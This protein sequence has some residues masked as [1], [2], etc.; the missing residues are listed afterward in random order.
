MPFKSFLKFGL[1]ILTLMAVSHRAFP[2]VITLDMV[3]V[4]NAG[5]PTDSGTGSLYGQVNTVYQ[6]QRT[7]MNLTQYTAFLNAVAK[8]DTFN[9]Y[10]T[11]MASIANIAGISRSGP[12]GNFTY[13]V[14]G[15]GSRPVTYVTWFD[16]ARFANWMANGQPIGA[17]SASTTE[18][19]AYNI[20]GSSSG[21]TIVKNTINPNTGSAVT[22]WIPTE[23]EWYK[24]AYYDPSPGAPSS[25]YWLYPT[26]S[27]TA[28]GNVV[29]PAT[30]QANY[31][32]GKY[33]VTQSATFSGTQNYLTI[34]GAYS[35]SASFYGT[36][37]QGGGVMEWTGT[38]GSNR[39]VRGGSW[40]ADATSLS[41]STRS[42]NDAFFGEYPTLGFRLAAIPEPSTVG[43]L[44]LG[45]TAWALSRRRRGRS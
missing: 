9:L 26:R 19:G 34:G 18:N 11:S 20:N 6:I 30:N 3:L 28:P 8:A 12:S 25:K 38:G 35:N 16:A 45:A 31:N 40:F 10:N 2:A 4:G 24:A 13:S 39:V 32:N 17:Q 22:F 23:D 21:S 42:S 36:F 41:S 5:N 43:F 44:L 37:D 14:I 29:G 1:V 27:N 7:E 15:D 33:S